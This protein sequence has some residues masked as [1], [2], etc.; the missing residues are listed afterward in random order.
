MIKTFGAYTLSSSTMD[1]RH[2]VDG[3]PNK[4]E[5]KAVMPYK[6]HILENGNDDIVK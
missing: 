1:I 3:T 6:L 2:S 5:E 4:I